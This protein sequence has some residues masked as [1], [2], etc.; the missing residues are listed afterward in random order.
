MFTQQ[1]KLAFSYLIDDVYNNFDARAQNVA[2]WRISTLTNSSDEGLSGTGLKYQ[3]YEQDGEYV[4][5]IAGTDFGVGTEQ[6][7]IDFIRD[8]SADAA[9]FMRTYAEQFDESLR[10]IDAFLEINNI[11]PANVTF[12]GHS[13]GGAHAQVL[14]YTFGSKG[15]TFDAPGV[16]GILDSDILTEQ[17][18]DINYSNT[19]L[20]LGITQSPVGELY[21]E[22][23]YEEGSVISAGGVYFSED[24][25][26]GSSTSVNYVDDLLP[27]LAS[28]LQGIGLASRSWKLFITGTMLGLVDA[29]TPGGSHDRNNFIAAMEREAFEN[30]ELEPLLF[31]MKELSKERNFSEGEG[32][33]VSFE[34][35]IQSVKNA[36][37]AGE[38]STIREM[39]DFFRVEL[40]FIEGYE[41]L[42]R[43]R[44]SY[45][46]RAETTVKLIEANLNYI[47]DGDSVLGQARIIET[48]LS[49]N[50][51]QLFQQYF[52]NINDLQLG[53]LSPEEA[54]TQIDAQL[55]LFEHDA[56]SRFGDGFGEGTELSDLLVSRDGQTLWGGG[57]DDILIADNTGATLK[58]D[59]YQDP[60]D[61][62]E[63]P[64]N[65]ILI[66]GHGDDLLEGGGGDD[67][68]YGGFGDDTLSGG[69]GSDHLEGGLGNDTYIYNSGD[70]IDTILDYSGSIVFD[71]YVLSG[72]IYD[73]E[74]DAYVSSDGRFSYK[75]LGGDLI[76]NDVL[77]VRDFNSGDLGVVLFEPGESTSF[78]T[79]H[80]WQ[81]QLNMYSLYSGALQT[82]IYYSY[83][84]PPESEIPTYR[85][86]TT[87]ELADTRGLQVGAAGSPWNYRY[88]NLTE[89]RLH[90]SWGFANPETGAIY[91]T[92]VRKDVVNSQSIITEWFEELNGYVTVGTQPASMIFQISVG[93]VLREGHSYGAT[94]RDSIFGSSDSDAIF[95]LGGED[96][97]RSLGG[98]DLIEINHGLNLE[99]DNVS[100]EVYAGNG[101]DVIRVKGNRTGFAQTFI[102]TG[103]GNDN[104]EIVVGTDGLVEVDDAAGNDMV[105]VT[106]SQLSESGELIYKYGSGFDYIDL[107]LKSDLQSY[108]ATIEFTNNLDRYQIVYVEPIAIEGNGFDQNSILTPSQFNQVDHSNYIFVK[109][110]ITNEGVF[111]E[112]D[113]F[114]EGTATLN[115]KFSDTQLGF[116]EIIEMLSHD[117]SLADDKLEGDLGIDELYGG[118]GNDEIDGFEGN[119][120]LFGDSGNDI[121]NGGAGD[122][123]LNGGE[124]LDTLTGDEGDDLLDGGLG[125]DRY[126]YSLGDGFDTLIEAESETN[127]PVNRQQFIFN[128]EDFRLEPRARGQLSFLRRAYL[129][130]VSSSENASN[131]EF[132]EID[133]LEFGE[134]ITKDS[135]K[136]KISGDDLIVMV[137][138][139]GNGLQIKNWNINGQGIEQIDFADGTTM[140]FE[141][142]VNIASTSGTEDDDS[143]S[144][145]I[146]DDIV[147][148]YEGNDTLAAGDGD[149]FIEGGMGNDILEGGNGNDVYFFEQ[150]DG[151]DIIL[152]SASDEHGDA[153]QFGETVSKDNVYFL[154]VNNDLRIAF[155]DSNDSITISNWF[156]QNQ[157]GE[158]LRSVNRVEFADGTFY[159]IADIYSQMGIGAPSQYLV[160]TDNDDVLQ[161]S[162]GGDIVLGGSGNDTLDGAAG[163]D[164][165]VGGVGSDT[166]LFGYGSGQDR[167]S[168]I[169]SDNTDVNIILFGE[170]I[171]QQDIQV[172]RYGSVG[173]Q[174]S[175]VGTEDKLRIDNWFINT[176]TNEFQSPYQIA[177]FQFQDGTT[178]QPSD[179]YGLLDIPSPGS[180][181]SGTENGDRLIGTSVGE[182]IYGGSGNDHLDGR[183]GSDVIFGGDGDD[184]IL[185]GNGNDTLHAGEGDDQVTGGDGNDIIFAGSGSNFIYAG[186]GEDT[187]YG[188]V[189]R[190]DTIYGGNGN[191]TVFAQSTDDEYFNSIY[192]EAGDDNL[193]GHIG[194]DWLFGGIG[195]DVLSGGQGRDLL[196]GNEGND[197][198]R[199]N[200][201]DGRDVI[202][203]RSFDFS[204]SNVLVLGEGI[205]QE[206]LTFSM[207]ESSGSESQ[208][209]LTMNYTGLNITIEGTDDVLEIRDFFRTLINSE[210][211]EEIV[212][213][214]DTA[215]ITEI[216]FADGTTL[217]SQQIFDI[218]GIH[219]PGAVLRGTDSDDHLLGTDDDD[220]ID[221]GAGNDYI[222]G[223][224]GS[225][226]YLYGTGSGND[227]I[228]EMSNLSGQPNRVEFK[229]GITP[230]DLRV[231]RTDSGSLTF[232]II[233]TGEKLRI[234]MWFAAADSNEFA[235]ELPVSQFI[236]SDGTVWT[237][238]VLREFVDSRV[239]VMG[240]DDEDFILGT[241]ANDIIDGGAGDDYM[242]GGFGSDTYIYGRGSGNDVIYEFLNL[243]EEPNRVEFKEDILPDDLKVVRSSSGSLTFEILDTGEKLRIEQ[244]F[245]SSD[246]NDFAE[247]TPIAEFVFADGTVWT[248]DTL[249]ALV[250]SRIR[251]EGSEEDDHLIGTR[252]DDLID[253]GA[254]DDYM[255]GG[256]GADTYIYGRGS[257]NDIIFEF[258]NLTNEPNRVEFKS[259]VSPEHLRIV[260]SDF[261]SLLI[262]IIDSGETLRILNWYSSSSSDDFADELPIAEFIF[263]DGTVWTSED[264]ENLIEPPADIVGSANDDVLFG[265]SLADTMY[266]LD[267]ND[268]LLGDSGN[269][270]LN[271][272]AGDD[273]LNGGSGD[274]ILYGD[275]GN[276]RLS[277]ASGNDTLVSGTGDDLLE[278]G[279]GDDIYVISFN[280]GN[281]TIDEFGSQFDEYNVI[282][283]TDVL[284]ENVSFQRESNS[285]N[286]LLINNESGAQVRI[287][288]WFAGITNGN[289]EVNYRISEIRF[290]DGT[291]FSI[292]EIIDALEGVSLEPEYHGT[293]SSDFLQGSDSADK[294][295]GYSGN[296]NL[297]G[298]AGNDVLFG[299][300]G[301]DQ[302]RG[303]EGDDRLEGGRGDDTYWFDIGD[304][305]D[306]ISD[307]KGTDFITFSPGVNS[308]LVEVS[309]YLNEEGVETLLIKYGE[310]DSITIENWASNPVELIRFLGGPQW[311]HASINENTPLQLSEEADVFVDG[312]GGEAISALGGDDLIQAMGGND[313]LIG[314]AGNDRLEGGAGR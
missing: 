6:E 304:G 299:M 87:E 97:I 146:Q 240:S 235:N 176:E 261:N 262:E 242:D 114:S 164:L 263:S 181:I 31:I 313:T 25:Y 112:I 213:T 7:R 292:D 39:E 36:V 265:T 84:E 202:T 126:Q 85:G 203:E 167:I 130:N 298:Y 166:Y 33:P 228:F 159:D 209:I 174:I 275:E 131:Q 290:S 184:T 271:A 270:T 311:D 191:D 74:I 160:G 4:I 28:A 222:D 92:G 79:P 170:G 139:D 285:N 83:A 277:G 158:F 107:S 80:V 88:Y 306:V 206:I 34:A 309:R 117:G 148:G 152:D 253:G 259:D 93:G 280:G 266:G 20:N 62:T 120:R 27:N 251:V 135:I 72:G 177:L 110:T 172:T 221:G 211:G 260:R 295:W 77:T 8:A 22:N 108:I 229:E 182:N 188:T 104:I 58:G 244:W 122:D 35:L 17:T 157:N 310:N 248:R 43:I 111:L 119:D 301:A 140:T 23:I 53:S 142:I 178:L 249:L 296:D 37:D 274:D 54:K 40:A 46:D 201:G 294:M 214:P 267:G 195:N 212:S 18:L 278:G 41:E 59:A 205:T 238:E 218:L 276:N 223:G 98:D 19:L 64:G 133:V 243:S 2:G 103:A 241:D 109:D 116:S 45:L 234:E 145:S 100:S 282:Q 297:D 207:A 168:E 91:T 101:N 81:S 303:G 99:D 102:D 10:S 82:T 16:K 273:Y 123:E 61:I 231:T 215:A 125:N 3:V 190:S 210:T 179:I 153:I 279:S 67:I 29:G 56:I 1:Q 143:I 38:I 216:Q 193:N 155:T 233:E 254:G 256:F 63:N 289:G 183:D 200:L 220:I 187:I 52:E 86:M 264:I 163:N 173:I 32:V 68:I 287:L 21:V 141:D 237:P 293:S 252:A 30:S 197:I 226:T 283:F 272:G 47:P 55:I 73:S 258:L 144:G 49:D 12:V 217:T 129:E 95:G 11:D 42:A 281:D 246:S 302:L 239:P 76:I 154:R 230:D 44:N 291:V 208:G 247:E 225:D 96:E 180:D 288:D 9:L 194:S 14:A 106:T 105:F 162:D 69:D 51:S 199:Y 138:N 65:D 186:D 185:G 137:D 268:T 115:L 156:E 78:H 89:S 312:N 66:G 124:G 94:G 286:L 198:Y 113:E 151:S 128:R 121:L 147:R 189:D 26:V 150:G 250:D 127:Q 236:F 245:A 305:H 149:D 257:G 165:L 269:D 255:D 308:E 48:Q 196:E 5:A 13:L 314:G 71:G 24:E 132:T 15:L 169:N 175:I 227:T 219:Y 171:E 118:E 134:G 70:G 136:F 307:I 90:Y 75:L 50:L 300:D 192:G 161:G 284:S 57:G 60:E 224:F 232:E 204:E